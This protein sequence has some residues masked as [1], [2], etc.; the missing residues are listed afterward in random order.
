MPKAWSDALAAAVAAGKIPNIPPTTQVPYQQPQYQSGLNP[1]SPEICASSFKGCR[2]PKDIW[3]APDGVFALNF[4][5]GPLPESDPL[6]DYLKS[7]NQH[8]T[9]FMIGLNVMR[10]PKQFMRAF[11]ELDD[12]IAGH[13]WSHRYMTTLSNEDIVAEFG[14]TNQII[15]DMTGGR[16]P[17]YWRPPTGDSDNRVRAIAE[18]VFGMYTVLWNQDTEDWSLTTGGTTPQ[19]VAAD[20]Q[21]WITG[22]KSPGLII[23]EHE[24]SN[25]SVQAFINAFPLVKENG[26]K[27][28]P[29]TQMT[30]DMSSW[31]NADDNTGAV[32]SMPIVGG[33]ASAGPSSSAAASSGSASASASSG[34]VSASA[35]ASRPATTSKSGTLLQASA[36]SASASASAQAGEKNAA[37]ATYAPHALLGVLSAAVLPLLLLA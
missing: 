34:S 31:Q 25:M 21:K 18:E 23:L 6:Y 12:D 14:Y 32:E 2:N 17:A 33:S 7:E 26:W 27:P 11:Q 22:P 24:L 37:V 13:T 3:D 5:D 15:S 35:S 28:M 30:D 9:H 19:K 10:N 16:L 4:D 36:S 8:A 1:N 29:V 20:L